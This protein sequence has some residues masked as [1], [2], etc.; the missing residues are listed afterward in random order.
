MIYLTY[1]SYN[2]VIHF[3]HEH[4][5]VLHAQTSHFCFNYLVQF[6]FNIFIL[7]I[8]YIYLAINQSDRLLF[9]YQ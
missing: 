2:A 9:V 6:I 3:A 7:S 1:I 8:V 5:Y 4:Y